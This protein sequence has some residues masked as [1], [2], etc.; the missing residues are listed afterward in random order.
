[1]NDVLIDIETLGTKQ[2]CVIVSIGAVIFNR[3]DEPGTIIDEFEVYLDVTNQ[4]GRVADPGT[5]LWWMRDDMAEARKQA[6]KPAGRV[7]LGLGLKNLDDFIG[8]HT[9]NECWGCGPSFDM[10]ILEHAYE[11][12]K[13]PFPVPFWKW[14]CVRTIESFFYGKNTRKDGGENWIG[15]TAHAALDDCKMEALVIQKSYNAVIKALS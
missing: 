6:F 5:M 1:M 12:H 2:N 14:S 13:Q 15:G 10:S 3:A 11:Q 7:R 9:V 4:Q 8:G